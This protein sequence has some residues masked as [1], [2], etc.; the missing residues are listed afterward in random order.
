MK[1]LSSLALD[2]SCTAQA[3]SAQERHIK[4]LDE[5][6]RSKK[7]TELEQ[8]V[9]KQK[10]RLGDAKRKLKV[11]EESRSA[12]DSSRRRGAQTSTNQ[13]MRRRAL[14][15]RGFTGIRMQFAGNSSCGVT[16]GRSAVS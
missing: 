1:L 13:D 14:A 12:A 5:E 3:Q 4:E 8:E 16:P 11:R 7:L 15:G 6:Y 10:K 2:P 9:F